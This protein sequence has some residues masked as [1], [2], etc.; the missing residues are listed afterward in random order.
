MNVVILPVVSKYFRSDRDGVPDCRKN[1]RSIPGEATKRFPNGRVSRGRRDSRVHQETCDDKETADQT[2]TGA[3][4]VAETKISSDRVI[5]HYGVNDCAEGGARCH[6]SHGQRSTSLEILR[7]N[8][9]ARDVYCASTK[10][11][12]DALR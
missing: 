4:G 1:I 8:C 11:G 7:N 10:A 3:D 2:C 5:E 6:D 12:T 9:Q